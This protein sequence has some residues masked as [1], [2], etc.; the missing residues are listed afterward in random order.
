MYASHKEVK[1]EAWLQLWIEYLLVIATT[2]DTRL[3]DVET[4]IVKAIKCEPKIVK[5]IIQHPA[6]QIPISTKLSALWAVRKAGIKVED[7]TEIMEQFS[8]N[9]VHSILSNSD[10][11]RIMALRLLVETNKTTELLTLL[12]CENLLTYLEYN[13]NCQSPATRQKM[14][15]LFDKALVRCELNLVK[16]LKD[17]KPAKPV[18]AASGAANSIGDDAPL[19]L[20]F[21]RDFIRKLVENLFQVCLRLF[22]GVG[23]C[24]EVNNL[25]VM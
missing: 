5:H 24:S 4:L 3:P 12:E 11:T 25:I 1:Y 14:L 8:N 10:E 16:L 18:N 9:L 23:L 13:S 2:G 15:A 20:K 22:S 17:Y 19:Q 7:F 21:L 6:T